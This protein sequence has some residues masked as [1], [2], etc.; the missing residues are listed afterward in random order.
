ME[1]LVCPRCESD[2]MLESKVVFKNGTEHVEVRCQPCGKFIK[3]KSQ[4]KQLDE[5]KTFHMPIGKHAGKI[6]EEIPKDYLQW[7]MDN[8]SQKNLKKRIKEY[9]DLSD[10]NKE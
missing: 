6:L 1:T 4:D 10:R 7:A 8:F 9:L 5:L 3:Y 2:Q